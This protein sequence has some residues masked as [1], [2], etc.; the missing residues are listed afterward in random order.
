M[1]MS[2]PQLA[3]AQAN[4]IGQRQTETMGL[5]PAERVKIICEGRE[6]S[7]LCQKL[8]NEPDYRDLWLDTADKLTRAE[9]AVAAMAVE[10]QGLLDR[11]NKAIQRMIERAPKLPDG[12]AIFR[13]ED[14]RFF[15]VDGK[16]VS[17]EEAATAR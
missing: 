1:A 14:G 8:T 10:A 16:L 13:A 11:E 17:L 15:D 2:F 3:A 6:A 5:P 4:N 12:R 9:W 7:N